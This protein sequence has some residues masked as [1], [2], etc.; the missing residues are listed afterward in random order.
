MSINLTWNPGFDLADLFFLS[1]QIRQTGLGMSLASYW[2]CDLNQVVS[3]P[4]P[5]VSSS[6][7]WAE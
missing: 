4:Y 6:V 7:K 1:C 3:S 5:F 2:L